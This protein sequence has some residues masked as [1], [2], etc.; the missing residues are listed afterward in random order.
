MKWSSSSGSLLSLSQ[1]LHTR[2][3][4][5]PSPCCPLSAGL[6]SPSLRKSCGRDSPMRKCLKSWTEGKS[7]LSIETSKEEKGEG[8]ESWWRWRWGDGDGM[9]GYERRCIQGSWD[10]IYGSVFLLLTP[11]LPPHIPPPQPTPPQSLSPLNG[12][13]SPGGLGGRDSR[14]ATALCVCLSIGGGGDGGGLHQTLLI[15]HGQGLSS[16]Q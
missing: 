11:L 16:V 6:G 14:A 10:V 1:W 9:E 13:C 3:C 5:V 15:D 7:I 8:G 4:S 12:G 2:S